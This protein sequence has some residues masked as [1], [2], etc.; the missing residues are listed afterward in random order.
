MLPIHTLQ[1]KNL[2]TLKDPM[3]MVYSSDLERK[4]LNTL[5]LKCTQTMQTLKLAISD[6]QLLRMLQDPMQQHKEIQLWIK[7]DLLLMHLLPFQQEKISLKL[8]GK[9]LLSSDSAIL[10]I[11]SSTSSVWSTNSKMVPGTRLIF[12]LTGLLSLSRFTLTTNSWLA[13][14]SS[15]TARQQLNQQIHLYFTI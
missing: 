2:Q 10:I 9:M 15:Q 1:S 14:S 4:N 13:T 11:R 12:W 3:M 8:L 5:R 6:W 7:L